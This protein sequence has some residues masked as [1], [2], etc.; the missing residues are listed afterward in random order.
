VAV[1]LGQH[2][3]VRARID[4]FTGVEQRQREVAPQA[5]GRG[6]SFGVDDWTRLRRFLVLGSEGG[7]YYA[8]E[9]KL[10]KENADALFRCIK[11]DGRRTVDEIVAIVK[12][13]APV[14]AG[15]NLED[16]SAPRCF[17]IEMRLREA[18]DIPV[19]HD[20]QHGTAI[21]TLAA[22]T[23]AREISSVE[24]AVS[25]LGLENIQAL[26][27][28]GSAFRISKTLER[29][30]DVE[31]LRSSALRRAAIA[32]SIAQAEGWTPQE[33]G[34][35]VLSCMLRDVGGLVLAEGYP[36]AAQRLTEIVAKE[37]P[38]HPVR[39]AE[40]EVEAYGCSVTQ[41]S[42]HLLGL[43]GFS[44]AV[45]HTVGSCPLVD[46]GPGTTPYEHVLRFAGLR[47]WDPFVPVVLEPGDYVNSERLRA[48]NSAADEVITR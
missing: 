5:F 30:V 31:G 6:F 35:A 3:P 42:A 46:P 38:I 47:A 9:Q 23:N 22:L 20:D 17:E 1:V 44:P 13:I 48:W 2:V 21:V 27:L 29:I 4:P 28:T 8:S 26:V 15:I 25:L 12:G 19:F 43:W 16:I 45:V 33:R 10:T 34:L 32:R 14:F 24:S 39:Q 40:L 41:A 7:S 36:D 18:L 37:G 11:V